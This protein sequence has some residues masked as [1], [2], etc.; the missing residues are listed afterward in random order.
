MWKILINENQL[1][2]W[3]EAAGRIKEDFGI[4]RALGYLIGEK[5]YSIVSPLRSCEELIRTID[6]E[7]KNPDYN[8]VGVTLYRS[9]KLVTN[10]HEIYKKEI[11]IITETEKLLFKF[12]S[13]I[14]EAFEPYEIRN[15]FKSNPRFGMKAHIASDEEYEFLAGR[16]IVEHSLDTEIDDALI[17]GEIMK[18][19]HISS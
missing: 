3:V 2:E 13:L 9:R 14:R 1:K 6:E 19:F 10:L 12:A 5:F 17:C 16:G 18:Y 7:M 8:P 15:Y 4:D 11:A